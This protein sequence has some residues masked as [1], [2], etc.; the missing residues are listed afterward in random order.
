MMK[1]VLLLALFSAVAVAQTGFS[2]YYGGVIFRETRI[3]NPWGNE[4]TE[5]T[6]GYV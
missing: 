6:S 2:T 1:I 4:T 5:G 3:A